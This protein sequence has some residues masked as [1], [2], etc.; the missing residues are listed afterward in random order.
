MFIS[1][2]IVQMLIC[3]LLL[4]TGDATTSAKAAEHSGANEPNTHPMIVKMPKDLSTLA[5]ER[6]SP[7]NRCSKSNPSSCALTASSLP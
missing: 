2:R 5:E 7:L 1:R 6:P 4:V 3:A